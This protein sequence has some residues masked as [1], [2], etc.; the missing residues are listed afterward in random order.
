MDKTTQARIANLRVYQKPPLNWWRKL[1]RW[2]CLTFRKQDYPVMMNIGWTKWP[3]HAVI[4]ADVMNPTNSPGNIV[5]GP[6]FSLD[7]RDI[8]T[9]ECSDCSTYIKPDEWS[10][11]GAIIAKWGMIKFVR[12]CEKC[13]Q[14]RERTGDL[15]SWILSV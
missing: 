4:V 9:K 12:Y 11:I 14:E 5:R 3:S 13:K 10:F 6:Q 1:I 2:Y 8:E 15:F 7:W